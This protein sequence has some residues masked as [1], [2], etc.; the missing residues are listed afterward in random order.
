MKFQKGNKLGKKFTKGF[1]P[2]WNQKGKALS[3]EH[4]LK[5]SIAKKGVSRPNMRGDK[6]PAWKGGITPANTSIRNSK[7]YALWRTAVFERDNHTCIWCGN[8]EGGNLNADHIKPFALFP[9]LR[10]AIDNGRTLCIPCHKTTDTYAG[11]VL[12]LK[13]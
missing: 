11:R 7:E 13:V 4:K 6:N 1:V 12:K 2:T 8:N 9:E 3:P 10:F 5:L